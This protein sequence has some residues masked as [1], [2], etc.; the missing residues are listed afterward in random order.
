M[1]YPPLGK[2]GSVKKFLYGNVEPLPRSFSTL[3]KYAR[4]PRRVSG[5]VFSLAILTEDGLWRVWVWR[6]VLE[7]ELFFRGV[8][9]DLWT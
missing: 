1:L 3:R 7:L 4:V 9:Y 6:G 2:L 5:K 8:D